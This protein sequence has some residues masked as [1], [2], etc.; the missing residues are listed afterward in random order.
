MINE[1]YPDIYDPSYYNIKAEKEDT[2]I[3]CRKSSVMAH[4]L[5]GQVSLPSFHD[6]KQA[7]NTELS[8]LISDSWYLFSVSGRKFF[9]V[10]SHPY[11]KD[12]REIPDKISLFEAADKE[13]DF[14]FYMNIHRFRELMDPKVMIFEA[15][16]GLHMVL[17]KRSR[18]Y[19]GR[20]GAKAVP[21]KLERA[22]VCPLCKNTEYP[23]ISPAVIVAITNKDKILL[24][25]NK[26]GYYKKLALVSGYVEIGESFEETVNREVFEEVGIR[27]KNLKLYKD[28]PWGL[29]GAHM[30]GY[31]A[32][33]DGD[34]TLK[35]QESEISEANWYKREDI[36]DYPFL[37]SVGN[38]LIHA[39]K[40]RLPPF[41]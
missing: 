21:S 38:E 28:Q 24:I 39:F 8:S 22:M 40:Y 26:L 19:C 37:M 10:T 34:D 30:I 18:E 29:S 27:V 20:C 36:P 31:T 33:L 41:A 35:L 23:K 4:M 5:K 16:T 9:T 3:C 7:L 11:D 12:I 1:I 14:Y 6:L 15:A 25:K 32:E 2:A 13:D 17:W